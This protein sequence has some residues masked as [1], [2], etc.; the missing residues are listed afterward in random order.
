[1]SAEPDHRAAAHAYLERG[2]YPVGWVI[3]DGRKAA[4]S[5]KGRHY[6]DYQPAHAD[7]DRWPDRWQ[8]GLA[9]CQRSGFWALDF[10]C[11][12][13]RAEEFFASWVAGQTVTQLTARGF[14][15]VYRGAGYGNP[16]PRDGIWAADWPDV[17]VRSNGFIAAWPSLHPSGVQY[18]W[19][20]DW[21]PAEP[22]QLLLAWRPERV[23][24]TGSGSNGRA[25]R[26]GGPD[27]DLAF[28][29]EHGIEL[30]W[31]DDEL[32]RLACR[33][34]RTMDH[35]ELYG[36]LWAAVS[37]SAQKPGDPWRPADVMAKIRRAAEFTQAEDAAAMAAYD[38]WKAAGS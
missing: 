30:G 23:A 32:W 12:Q 25:N 15:R 22:P 38:G 24:R 18:R 7:I 37:A 17:Q 35:R 28:Y 1:V 34:V 8:V 13:D 33:H 11:G 27:G 6:N 14:H 16:W 10:D 36:W 21:T 20:N 26:D 3:I 31:Q 19:L 4:V 9:M 2:F 29:A 5:M